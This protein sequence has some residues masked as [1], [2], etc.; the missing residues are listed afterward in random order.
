VIFS[1]GRNPLFAYVFT[2]ILLTLTPIGAMTG[3]QSVFWAVGLFGFV[4]L[5][6]DDVTR[7]QPRFFGPLARVL[8]WF[9]L[10][11]LGLQ[12]LGERGPVGRWLQRK[13]GVEK[14]ER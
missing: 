13:S 5:M 2:N 1:L 4:I 11:L 6:T 9:N 14:A 10:R 8:R 3:T 7:W 12:T